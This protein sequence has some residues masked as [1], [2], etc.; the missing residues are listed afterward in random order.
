MTGASR[1]ILLLLAGTL[2]AGAC[3]DF[4]EVGGDF[5]AA[6]GP[7]SPAAAG[8]GLDAIQRDAVGNLDASGIHGRDVAATS[9][10]VGL[11]DLLSVTN[12][13]TIVAYHFKDGWFPPVTLPSAPAGTFGAVAATIN[14]RRID[15]VAATTSHQLYY[16]HS[17]SNWEDLNFTDWEEIVGASPA[18]APDSLALI[19]REGGLLDAF[20]LAESGNIEHAFGD[21]TLGS[22]ESGDDPGVPYL[23]PL[24]PAHTLNAVSPHAG[25]VDLVLDGDAE[26]PLQHHFY[27]VAEGGWGTSGALY[28]EKLGCDAVR[29]TPDPFASTPTSFAVL[30]STAGMIEVFSIERSA[31]DGRALWH[32]TYSV[33]D[34][35][36]GEDG[37]V[38]FREID[39]EGDAPDR[40]LDATVSADARHDLYGTYDDRDSVWWL[41]YY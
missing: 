39:V 29:T 33:H 24:V 36:T 9:R 27:D 20:W 22:F 32:G 1:P 13:G 12:A 26:Y 30:S 31:A 28:R 4:R 17:G 25:R 38:W 37:R 10:G 41:A 40:L 18:A 11:A 35:W 21:H 7:P 3:R 16:A 23:R 6:G 19:T 2:A 5:A 14:G 34:G 8:D 15:V